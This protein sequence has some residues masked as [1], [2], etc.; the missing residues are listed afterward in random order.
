MTHP[1]EPK[2]TM[3]NND[4]PHPSLGQLPHDIELEALIAGLDRLSGPIDPLDV[5]TSCR[6]AV[7]NNAP[8]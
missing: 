8:T 2:A 6:L 1:P 5:P 4:N 3:T 7:L